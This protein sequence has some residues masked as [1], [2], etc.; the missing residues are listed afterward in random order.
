M[1]SNQLQL[2]IGGGPLRAAHATATL[3][4]ALWRNVAAIADVIIHARSVTANVQKMADMLREADRL[5]ATA[6][7]RAAELRVA[8]R[9]VFLA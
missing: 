3:A 9:Q 5:E 8:A 4:K 1:T 6:P 2:H 7:A